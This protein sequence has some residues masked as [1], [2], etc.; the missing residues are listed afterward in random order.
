MQG[1]GRDLTACSHREGSL[2]VRDMSV[3]IMSWRDVLR[4]YFQWE[5]RA[6]RMAILSV[7]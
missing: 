3:A 7:W 1:D 2:M 4:G 6:A 5:T